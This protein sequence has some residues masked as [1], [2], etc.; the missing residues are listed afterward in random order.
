MPTWALCQQPAAVWDTADRDGETPACCAELAAGGWG[1]VANPTTMSL[2]Q[3]V[4]AGI[5]SPGSVESL[6]AAQARRQLHHLADNGA[7]ALH[8][9]AAFNGD[10]NF[11]HFT[12]LVENLLGCV[13]YWET[14]ELP[15]GR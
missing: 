6:D 13:G 9:P 15:A 10:P 11:E 14:V 4:L 3:L 2:A 7:R 8:L 12:V 1:S 5:L